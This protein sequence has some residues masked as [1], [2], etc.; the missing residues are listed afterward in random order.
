MFTKSNK[1][2][3]PPMDLETRLGLYYNLDSF[4]PKSITNSVRSTTANTPKVPD[5]LL[6][7]YLDNHANG[8]RSLNDEAV[9]HEHRER[10]AKSLLDGTHIDAIL[11]RWGGNSS[12][13]SAFGDEST[14]FSDEDFDQASIR[15]HK[16]Q[17]NFLE[18]E[19]NASNILQYSPGQIEREMRQYQFDKKNETKE[20]Y[21]GPR[22]ILYSLDP[23]KHNKSKRSLFLE[24]VVKRESAHNTLSQQSKMEIIIKN[25]E[26]LRTRGGEAERRK[27]LDFNTQKSKIKLMKNLKEFRQ[28]FI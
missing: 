20:I 22:S 28:V 11:P 18:V 24:D 14:I 7:S 6:N 10:I 12:Q 15:E 19:A 5:I 4:T 27:Q 2:A 21:R 3:E 1:E 16:R 8:L 26:E 13:S 23:S 25:R 17:T 9:S